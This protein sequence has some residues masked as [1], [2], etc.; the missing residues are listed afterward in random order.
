VFTVENEPKPNKLISQSSV[1]MAAAVFLLILIMFFMFLAKTER[2]GTK[3][4][5]NQCSFMHF[6]F[7]SH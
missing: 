1:P 7:T 2:K 6:S 4:S 5:P 3:I